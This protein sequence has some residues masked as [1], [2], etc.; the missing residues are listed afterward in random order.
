MDRRL[1]AFGRQVH[2]QA[3]HTPRP[4]C[5]KGAALFASENTELASR[6]GHS[7][8]RGRNKLCALEV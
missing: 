1:R 3:G 5:S 6:L 8:V 4:G 2:L 7:E